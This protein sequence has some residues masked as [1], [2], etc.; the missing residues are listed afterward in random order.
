MEWPAESPDG[1]SRAAGSDVG[2]LFEDHWLRLVRL[3]TLI[4]GRASVAEDI[5]GELFADLANRP[6]PIEY[7]AAYLRAAVVNRCHNYHRRAWRERGRAEDHERALV[8]S[9]DA[10]EV[11]DALR[12][13]SVRGRT[14]VVLR[15]WDDMTVDEVAKTMGCVPG[16]VSSLLHRAVKQLRK[17]LSP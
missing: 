12:A 6:R 17:E 13:L 15:Y 14:A 10:L 9:T 3:A 2:S 1:S 16:T 4:T 7:P 8:P 5:V 11:W